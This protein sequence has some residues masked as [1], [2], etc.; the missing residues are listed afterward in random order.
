MRFF[1]RLY[2]ACS[3]RDNIPD[4]E[5]SLKAAELALRKLKTI[6]GTQEVAL[7]SVRKTLKAI[8]VEPYADFVAGIIDADQIVVGSILADKIIFNP[9]DKN[10]SDQS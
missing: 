7:R 4:I 8:C 10:D 9:E 3:I 6:D 5:S 2:R 1:R